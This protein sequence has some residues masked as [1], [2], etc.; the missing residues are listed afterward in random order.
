M[1]HG[2]PQ[3]E[4][5][6]DWGFVRSALLWF[7]L[8]GAPLSWT[9]LLVAGYGFEEVSCSRGSSHW[10]F[11]AK[12]ATAA[13]FGAAAAIALAAAAAAALTW[14]HAQR[15]AGGDVRGRLEWMSYAGILVSGLFLCL[16]LM[17]GFGVTSLETCRH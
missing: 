8:L 5:A 17:T 10:G 6:G 2:R 11:E 13:L 3:R 12:T 15:P 16:I 9:I 1:I 14:R 7:G 4:R